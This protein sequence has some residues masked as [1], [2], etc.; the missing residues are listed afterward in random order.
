MLIYG[1]EFVESCDQ[2]VGDFAAC[3][4]SCNII[5][6]SVYF[7]LLQ[8]GSES[9]VG[10]KRSLLSY[11]LERF[12]DS[13]TVLQSVQRTNP[14]SLIGEEY[15]IISTDTFSFRILFSGFI[16]FYVS[17][18]ITFLIPVVQSALYRLLLR[19]LNSPSGINKVNRISSHLIL[20]HMRGTPGGCFRPAANKLVV[21]WCLLAEP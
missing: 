2:I 5:L 4:V 18:L 7:A 14:I 6:L 17:V 19:R 15:N 1:T 10:V 20:S 9:F 21:S 12:D 8:R 13:L 3:C 16:N 11:L